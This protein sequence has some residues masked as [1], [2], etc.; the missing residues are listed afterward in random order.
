[1]K[2]PNFE[3]KGMR[4]RSPLLRLRKKWPPFIWGIPTCLVLMIS[5]H[6]ATLEAENDRLKSEI[7]EQEQLISN[8]D[9]PTPWG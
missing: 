4:F 8:G 2:I 1:L 3:R 7:R 9:T 6:K 5:R